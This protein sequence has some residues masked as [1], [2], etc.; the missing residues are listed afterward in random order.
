MPNPAQAEALYAATASWVVPE[1]IDL[2]GLTAALSANLIP[3]ALLDDDWS[4]TYLKPGTKFWSILNGLPGKDTDWT[5]QD[6]WQVAYPIYS[7][8]NGGVFGWLSP[9]LTQDVKYMWGL[10]K[11][12]G[13]MYYGP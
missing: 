8:I 10:I 6:V 7:L 1:T 2:A 13:R 4:D 9:L 11:E 5:I 3:A 12:G